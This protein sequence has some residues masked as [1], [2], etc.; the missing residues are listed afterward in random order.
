[1]IIE[2]GTTT[3]PVLSHIIT[4]GVLVVPTAVHVL[5]LVPYIYLVKGDRT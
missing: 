4:Y 5:K 3:V 1:M 2:R